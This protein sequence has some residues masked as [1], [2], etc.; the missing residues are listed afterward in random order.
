MAAPMLRFSGERSSMVR[1]DLAFLTD[2]LSDPSSICIAAVCR[3]EMEVNR[4]INANIEVFIF[5]D[6]ETVYDLSHTL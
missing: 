3:L 1:I 4:S 6:F 5:E 2:F